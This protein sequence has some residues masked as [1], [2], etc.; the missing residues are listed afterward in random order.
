MQMG[1]RR[2]FE[3]FVSKTGT[4]LGAPASRRLTFP[5]YNHC[6]PIT[7]QAAA[8]LW[9]IWKSPAFA[10]VSRRD[11]GAPGK[12]CATMKTKRLRSMMRIVTALSCFPRLYVH[13]R[14]SQVEGKLR[15]GL[16]RQ[17]R[18]SRQKIVQPCHRQRHRL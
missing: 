12:S 14:A 17:S 11:A 2:I 16:R 7:T 15:R 5:H 1:T 8:V 9:L 6:S 4:I 10:S 3:V 18:L 13:K